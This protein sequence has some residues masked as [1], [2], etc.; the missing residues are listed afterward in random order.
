MLDRLLT[1]SICLHIIY[2]IIVQF[3]CLCGSYM[4]DFYF[5][6]IDLDLA[7]IYYTQISKY[8]VDLNCIDVELTSI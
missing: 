7:I 6:D 4:V 3:S 5:I 2:L 8:I 1:V